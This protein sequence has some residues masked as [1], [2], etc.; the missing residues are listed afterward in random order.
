MKPGV[1]P[2]PKSRPFF[3]YDPSASIIIILV[4]FFASQIIAAILISLYPAI[5]NWTS[6][7]SETWLKSSIGAQFAFILIAE[8]LAVS[9]VIKA[10]SMAKLAISKIGLVRPRLKDLGW[11]VVYYG[12]YFLAFIGVSIFVNLFTGIDTQ[13]EQQIGFETAHTTGQLL[14]VFASLVI[15]PPIAEEIM[16]RGFLFSSLRARFNY[17][18]ATI[19]SSVLFGIAH[20]QFGSSAPLLWIAAIDTFILACFLCHLRETMNSIWPPIFLHGLKNFVAFIVLF[21]PRLI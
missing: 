8:V 5:M 13:Q 4:I 9:M 20:L 17:W 15:L 14:L 6:A 21:G 19:V 10:V 18:T 12:L 7:E 3:R 1:A 2:A 11:A 16:F